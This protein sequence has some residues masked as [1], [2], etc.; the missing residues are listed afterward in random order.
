MDRV[1]AFESGV[2]DFL[3]RPFYP[4]ELGAR[5]LAVLR[6]FAEVRHATSPKSLQQKIVTVDTRAGRAFANERPLDLTSREFALL[7]ALV[8]QAGRVLT[9]H[10]LI[11]QIWGGHL[12]SSERTIDAHI[13]SIR[14]KLG[15]SRDCIE[16]V[17][18]VGYRFCEQ[19]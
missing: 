9:R 13:K 16:T 3:P 10:Q 1:L 4:P 14:R 7:A 6:G 11:E 18:G 19:C 15:G 8:Q 12:P 2:D 17:R 5:A